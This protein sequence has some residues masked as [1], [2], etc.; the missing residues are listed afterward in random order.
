MTNT[1]VDHS[2]ALH[3]PSLS[4]SLSTRVAQ[5]VTTQLTHTDR[6][7]KEAQGEKQR[8]EGEKQREKEEGEKE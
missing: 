4:L 2:R 3:Q 5:H 8:E 1:L 6:R 7:V